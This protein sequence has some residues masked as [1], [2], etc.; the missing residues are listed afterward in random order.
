MNEMVYNSSKEVLIETRGKDGRQMVH[1]GFAWIMQR[2][3]EGEIGMDD[4]LQEEGG[5]VYIFR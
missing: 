2:E 5:E 4:Y 1:Y 3:C